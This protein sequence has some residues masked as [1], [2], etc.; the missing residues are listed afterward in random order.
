MARLQGASS[1]GEILS[2]V[3]DYAAEGF[4]RVAILI[5]R[6]NEIFAIAGCGLPVPEVGPLASTQPL[7][8]QTLEEGWVRHVLETGEPHLGVP[9]TEVDRA[10][11]D[12]FGG[13]QPEPF[14]LGPV[15]SSSSVIA[16]IYGGQVTSD[17]PMPDTS[18]LEVA[19]HRAGL[20]LDRAAL[21]RALWEADADGRS[22]H[23]PL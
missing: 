20:A 10:L 13:E 3:L 14:Y 1:R 15:E 18:G 9:T 8:L 17:A 5:V 21:E 6:E 16:L 2:V 23:V 12:L 7:S 11:L 22:D 4:A 19:L